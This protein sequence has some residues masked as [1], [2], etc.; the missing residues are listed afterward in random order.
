M[1]RAEEAQGK[2]CFEWFASEDTNF[3][4]GCMLTLEEGKQF[5]KALE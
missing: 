1:F 4:V 2:L 3:I 5:R